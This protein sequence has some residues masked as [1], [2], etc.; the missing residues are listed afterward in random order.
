MKNYSLRFPKDILNQL[1]Q[2]L[3]NMI[4]NFWR[5]RY[6]L[7]DVN[8]T[9]LHRSIDMLKSLKDLKCLKQIILQRI[10]IF[11]TMIEN[12]KSHFKSS[13]DDNIYD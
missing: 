4:K 8:T 12:L 10:K 6:I 9:Y 7:Y 5:I 3:N 1:P 11:E 13:H 2:W